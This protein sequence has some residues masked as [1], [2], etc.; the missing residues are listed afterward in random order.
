MILE[1][2]QRSL[3]HRGC[4]WEVG[5][6]LRPAWL[7]H[8]LGDVIQHETKPRTDRDP[9][10]LRLQHARREQR[11]KAATRSGLKTRRRV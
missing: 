10:S 6:Y 5:E 11:F 3:I 4:G 7:K 1:P 8:F 9:T 2:S